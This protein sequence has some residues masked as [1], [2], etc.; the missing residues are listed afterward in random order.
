MDPYKGVGGMP[1]IGTELTGESHVF[2]RDN[3]HVMLKG[4]VIDENAVELIEKRLAVAAKE[5]S[6]EA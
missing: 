3:N 2:S 4:I 1:G 6:S 5:K